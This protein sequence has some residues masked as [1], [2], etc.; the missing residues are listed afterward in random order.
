MA[1]LNMTDSSQQCPSGLRQRTFSGTRTCAIN[2]DAATCSSIFFPGVADYSKVCGKILAYQFGNTDAFRFSTSQNTSNYV[3]GVSLTYDSLRQH[4][5]TFAA[6]LDEES[7]IT[8]RFNC[9]CISSYGTQ[10]PAFVGNDYFCDVRKGG[11]SRRGTFH[12]D[13]LLWDG[14][15]CRPQNECCSFNTPPWFFKQLPQP[16]TE[17]IEM[18]VCR[19]E[20]SD[21][22]DILIEIVEIYAQ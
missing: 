7:T 9:P 6:G 10:P 14:V 11:V 16:T 15:G 8:P 18:R 19:D 1:Y 5:W 21:N 3:D 2:S 4:I 13:S 20:D 12:G 17:D 22:E